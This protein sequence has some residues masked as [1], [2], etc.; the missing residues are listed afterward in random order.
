MAAVTNRPIHRLTTLLPRPYDCPAEGKNGEKLPYDLM[1]ILSL[2]QQRANKVTSVLP[3]A[4][5][6][7]VALLKEREN[8]F[9]IYCV[10]NFLVLWE[11]FVLSKKHIYFLYLSDFSYSPGYFANDG[12]TDVLGYRIELVLE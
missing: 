11:L 9:L 3:P 5:I 4:G 6:D 8:R 12:L 1:K 7:P 2:H 10:K